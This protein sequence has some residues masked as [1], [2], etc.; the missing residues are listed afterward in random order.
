MHTIGTPSARA[1]MIVLDPP[2]QT[3]TEVW[4]RTAAWG[5]LPRVI[6]TD[7]K[8]GAARRS[9]RRIG[10]PHSACHRENRTPA[11]PPP[12]HVTI[13]NLALIAPLSF[14]HEVVIGHI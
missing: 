13:R 3:T 1:A 14:L 12:A 8:A 9:G 11:G 7:T 5:A 2:W 10:S 4:G 6:P